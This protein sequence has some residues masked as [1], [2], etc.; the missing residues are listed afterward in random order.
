MT[1][2]QKALFFILAGIVITLGVVGG[3][4]Q[5]PNLISYDG[6]YL[7]AFAVIGLGFM[8][9]GSSYANEGNE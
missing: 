7:A 9:I 2:T 6:L 1:A 8:A 5:S 4:E 3:I